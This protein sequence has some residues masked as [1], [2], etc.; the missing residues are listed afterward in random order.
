MA[1]FG[2]IWP[3]PVKYFVKIVKNDFILCFTCN[4]WWVCGATGL[5]FIL[6]SL[7]KWLNEEDLECTILTNN[8]IVWYKLLLYDIM[9]QVLPISSDLG[10]CIGTVNNKFV[11]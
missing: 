5:I 6:N 9:T 3:R 8:S 1:K 11:T 7:N 4:A 2:H 10:C